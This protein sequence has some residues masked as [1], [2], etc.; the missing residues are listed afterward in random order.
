MKIALDIYGGDNSPYA[1]IDGAIQFI[2]NIKDDSVS[3]IL[4]GDE[5]LI[6]KYL[7]EKSVKTD[8]IEIVH[9]PDE[10]TCHDEPTSI[11]RKKP[12]SSMVKAIRCVADGEA[13]GVVSSGST[14]ALYAGSLSR[15]KR[16]RGITRPALTP[17]LPTVTGGK[18][19]LVDSGANADCIPEFLTQFALMGNAYMKAIYGIQ[20]PRITL[21]SNGTEDEKG[22]NLT[23]EAHALLREMP[24]NF[25][26]NSEAR[27]VFSGNADVV[28]CD[29]FTGNILLKSVEGTVKAVTVMLKA[30]LMSSVKSKIGALLIK[31]K[32][33]NFKKK[34]DYRE[35]G[36]A[37][38]LGIN[39]CVIKA[40]GTSD[41]KAYEKAL[42]QAYIFIK[43]DVVNEITAE[44]DN[45]K[46]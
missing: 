14:G 29:G 18:I 26:G 38:L 8:R 1:P 24:I 33:K 5:N 17:E 27:E 13:Q 20:E 45:M 11:V 41:A 21:L 2:R 4:T 35:I 43:K 42:E 3:V 44:L 10:I 36:G 7:E 34:F 6:K 32:M 31:D 16:I 39:G 40:H 37:P 19:L 12:E 46:I 30:E 28:V 9:A 22:N 23:C 15:I 25:I